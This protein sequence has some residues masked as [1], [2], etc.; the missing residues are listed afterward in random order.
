MYVAFLVAIC[1]VVFA[2]CDKGN[3]L[4]Q[5]GEKSSLNSL[6]KLFAEDGVLNFATQKE[7]GETLEELSKNQKDLEK[8]EKKW[9]DS[10]FISLRRAFKDI[11]EK[12]ILKISKNENLPDYSSFIVIEQDYSGEKE[13]VRVISDP[14]LATI[15]NKKG[16]IK[17]GNDMYKYYRDKVVIVRNY[18]E[19]KSTY[20]TNPNIIKDEVKG[21]FIEK[22]S[23]RVETTNQQ[24][25]FKM[26]KVLS[27]S[28]CT[29]YFDS[30]ERMAGVHEWEYQGGAIGGR[31][32]FKAITKNQKRFSGIWWASDAD[33]LE[34]TGTA[35]LI[36]IQNGVPGN[37]GETYDLSIS[38]TNNT[39][40]IEKSVPVQCQ[41]AAV[42]DPYCGC[43]V[44][45]SACVPGVNQANSQHS[46]QDE[47]TT[48]TCYI[49]S[50]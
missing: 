38:R 11:N 8:W 43:F 28:H 9:E 27:D 13:A 5:K 48:K 3:V 44:E 36:T 10:G 33:W 46:V 37:Y 42:W 47:G 20:L 39:N 12:D 16:L 40:W 23:R 29:N 49:Q 35:G 25:N 41:Y 31:V 7:F 19:S 26:G 14:I 15:V 2:S 4:E 32:S 6:K 18:N 21:I 34:Q 1:L 50:Q 22:I 30:N 17:I 24:K 45:I